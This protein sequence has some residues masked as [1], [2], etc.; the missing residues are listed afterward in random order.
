MTSEPAGGRADD[1]GE[2]TRIL[3][4]AAAGDPSAVDR[5]LPLV[6]GELRSLAAREMR[7]ERPDHTLQP[8]ALVHEA[9]LRLVNAAELGAAGRTHFFAQAALAMRRVLVDHARRRRSA[10]RGGSLERVP[11]GDP[12]Q[13]HQ[14]PFDLDILALDESLT[15]LARAHPDRVQVVEMRFFAGMTHEEIASALG[16]S[17]RTVERHWRFARAWLFRDLNDGAAPPAA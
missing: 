10:K 6:Y 2:V 1:R 8:T 4:A 11:L 16:E 14:P 3:A 15:R 9:Y 12:D 5:L 7:R 13:P 17:T